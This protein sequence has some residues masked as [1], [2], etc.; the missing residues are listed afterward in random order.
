MF[1][2]NYINFKKGEFNCISGGSIALTLTDGTQANAAVSDY[3]A[4]G[5]FGHHMKNAICGS[6]PS[7][8]RF[9]KD[10]FSTKC[11]I[12]LGSG[13]TPATRNDYTLESPITSGL[14][15]TNPSSVML[16]ESVEGRYVYSSTFV[17]GNTTGDTI[18]I[19]EIGIFT[20]V[21]N[22]NAYNAVLM[23]R[24]VFTEPI[25]IPAGESKLIN[26][27]VIF[28]QTLNVEA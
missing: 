7:T 6:I 12:Y 20:P 10:Y 1:T 21:Y 26:Y 15:M 3:L 27:K 2:Q 28:N 14:T 24:T 22:S 5:N 23:E 17:V 4:A 16:D 9:S 25:T 11:G 13:S 18:N 19:Y 8:T